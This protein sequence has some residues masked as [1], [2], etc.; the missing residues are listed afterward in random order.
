MGLPILID[1]QGEPVEVG[2][3]MVRPGLAPL[4]IDLWRRVRHPPPDLV[5]VASIAGHKDTARVLYS[6]G[7]PA[8]LVGKVLS[9]AWDTSGLAPS[10]E[11]WVVR[12]DV[13]QGARS[14]PGYPVEHAGPLPE[15]P[16]LAEVRIT[17]DIRAR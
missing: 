12:I 11:G 14:L 6:L 10:T 8:A 3:M 1:P 4:K 17:E 9:W 13:R 15:G 2:A 5:H 16:P 7:Q